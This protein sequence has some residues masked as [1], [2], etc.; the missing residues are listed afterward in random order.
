VEVRAL[1]VCELHAGDPRLPLCPTQGLV[2]LILSIY[3]LLHREYILAVLSL[4]TPLVVM[5][6]ISVSTGMVGV[7]QRRF[8]ND[9]LFDSDLQALADAE[10]KGQPVAS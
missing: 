1:H 5:M 9:L 2:I 10:S 3:F 6:M 8:I 4:A 7:V